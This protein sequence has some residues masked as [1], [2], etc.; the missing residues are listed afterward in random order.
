V[1]SHSERSRKTFTDRPFNRNIS[2]S[3]DLKRHSP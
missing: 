1:Q 3:Q 2:M